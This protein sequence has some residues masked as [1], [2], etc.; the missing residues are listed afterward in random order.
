MIKMEQR[1]EIF[2]RFCLPAQVEEALTR[3][4]E[5]GYAAYTV[6]G[7]VRDWVLGQTPHDYD[8]CTAAPP[9]EMKRVFRDEKTVETGIRHGTLTVILRGMPLEIT[10][11]RVDGDYKDGRHPEAV[12]FT[13]RIEEDLS[14]RD[15][16]VNAMAYSPKRGLADPF[17][18][19]ADCGGGVIRCVGEAE[20]RFSEDALRILR[21]LRF[22]ARLGF[23]IEEKTAKALRRMRMRLAQISRE[24]IAA[25]MT[26]L[27]LGDGAGK[28]LL[29]FPEVIA[30]AIP[31]LEALTGGPDWA[32]TARRTD[33]C[34]RREDVRWAAL[35]CGVN[36]QDGGAAA[37]EIMRGLKMSGK[38]VEEVGA[39]TAW[40]DFPVTAENA[41]EMLMRVGPEELPSLILLQQADRTARQPAE[42]EAAKRAAASALKKTEALIR[43][44]ACYSLAQLAVGGKDMAA[45]GLR[46]KE[47]GNALQGLLLRV[48]RNELP[49]DREALVKAARETPNA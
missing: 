44:G 24:R 42:A 27:L 18:G 25:E 1:E 36:R 21:A 19:Q 20:K 47:I 23:P 22:S 11:F 31:E 45:L 29:G 28:T 6:G 43:E 9:E 34:P 16:T 35:L 5:A 38:A 46:G 33:H 41:R 40:I 26:G 13:D 49:N 15:F 48:V 4:E 12:R 37:R 7:C 17:G 3:L 8:I 32:V 39:L 2:M 10:A 30:A 14:R